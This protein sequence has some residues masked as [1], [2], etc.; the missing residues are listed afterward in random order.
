MSQQRK[1]VV[2]HID[3]EQ[4]SGIIIDENCQDI[5]FSFKDLLSSVTINSWV[6]FEIVLSDNG[7]IATNIVAI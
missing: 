3:I 5:Y 2:A 4:N 6:Y 1:G 7:L